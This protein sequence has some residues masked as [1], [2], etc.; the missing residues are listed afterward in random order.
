MELKTL[1]ELPGVSGREEPV[2]MA[3]YHECIE[4][5]GAE[6]VTIDRM[7]NVIARK[8]GKDDAA[9]RVMV[10]AHM[11]EVGLMVLSAT[12]DGLL[13]IINIGGPAG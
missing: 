1:C 3:I 13:R 6:N 7:G 10:A 2:R 5:L 8:A 9:P 12:D 11:D 4:K